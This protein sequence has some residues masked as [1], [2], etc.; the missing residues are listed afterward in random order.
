MNCPVRNI[1]GDRCQLRADHPEAA[2]DHDY[3]PARDEVIAAL[4]RERDQA[5]AEIE[6]LNEVL[7]EHAEDTHLANEQ[8]AALLAQL[9][10]ANLMDQESA[11]LLA[12]AQ[13][14]ARKMLE[15]TR[16]IGPLDLDPGNPLDQSAVVA[17]GFAL[18]VGK[19]TEGSAHAPALHRCGWCHAA[20]GGTDA[21]WL[22]L[23]S[24]S[25]A[26]VHQHTRSCVHNPLVAERDQAQ[27]DLAVLRTHLAMD[28]KHADEHAEQRSS[29]FWFT[30]WTEQN[31]RNAELALEL[32]RV[33]TAGALG[34]GDRVEVT[35]VARLLMAEWERVGHGPVSDPGIGT[36]VE[37]ARAV[38][39][40]RAQVKP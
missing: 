11:E 25:T 27:R 20:A 3:P 19:L 17:Y 6:R 5:N 13:D 14:V 8:L 7:I 36:F 35:R 30:M 15:Q 22:A 26:D 16:A 10:P 31:Q 24:F 4:T 1:R 12:R 39:T 40:D 18:V 37:M 2:L 34:A 21:A 28:A 29:A 33:R 32:P 9:L 23:P 38:L